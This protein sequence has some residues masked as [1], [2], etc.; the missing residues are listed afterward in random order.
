M[1]YL[2]VGNFFFEK[3]A[4]TPNKYIMLRTAYGS[5]IIKKDTILY[6]TTDEEFYYRPNK[7]M[8]FTTIHPS[9]WEGI[10]YYVV[11]IQSHLE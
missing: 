8:L 2:E 6:H 11:K 3:C 7:P 10:N 9:E 1:D 4:Y 5:V